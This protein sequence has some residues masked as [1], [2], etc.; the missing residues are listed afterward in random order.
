MPLSPAWC[1]LFMYLPRRLVFLILI[2]FAAPILGQDN[3]KINLKNADIREFTTQVSAITGKSFIIDPRIKGNVTVISSTA[4]D[5]DAIYELFLSVLRVHGYA[6]VPAGRV[7]KIVQQT[8]AKQS[9]NPLDAANNIDSEE[10]ITKVIP[11]RNTP[12]AELVKI[13]RPMIP[14]YGHLAGLTEP[15]ALIISD[16][17]S[18]IA[19]LME[20]VKDIDVADT[21][22]TRIIQLKEAWVE[23]M[24]ALL[25]KLAPEQIGKGA[26][27]PNLVT[28]VASER[29]N[30]LVLKGEAATLKKIEEL[31]Q[32]LDVPANRA[33]TIQVVR[34]AHSDAEQL[35][36]ILKNL[37][38]DENEDNKG[39]QNVKTSI[40]AD[41]SL[42]A[43]VI[44]ANPTTMNELKDII[45]SLDVRRLQV[46]IEA[47]IMEVSTNFTRELGTELAI[48][49]QGSSNLPIAITQ[50]SGVLA[51]ILQSIATN[52]PSSANL[53]TRPLLGGGNL[54][55]SG[56]SFA[57]IIQAVSENSDVNLLS[58]PSIT[59]MDNEEAKI[60]VGQNVPFRTG[61]T[62]TGSGGTVNPFTTIQR[63]DVGLTLKVIPHVHD[64]NSIRLEIEQEVSE[65]DQTGTIDI[66]NDGSADL[67]TNI[68]TIETTVLSENGEVVIL[69][70][71]TR[72]KKSESERGV[73][74]LK[75]IP[76]I[77]YL[78]KAESVRTEKQNLLVFIR[79]TVIASSSDME[80]QTTRKY[81]NVWEV[82][83]EGT[84]PLDKLTDHFNGKR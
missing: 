18:N 83:I 60:V 44:R 25:E 32:E 14:Q 2:I 8:L 61:S 9:G 20:M 30:S 46:L 29:T 79:S 27:G 43:L 64:G 68:R 33:G 19:R 13:L 50:P 15:N 7:V 22:T 49:D 17:A 47:V 36:E 21:K 10:L 40:H 51:S 63:E 73:P 12:S 39:N 4:M 66:G 28:I 80:S 81:D 71:L 84:D 57:F 76:L 1:F 69:G 37:V 24:V 23:D 77:G 56:T 34:L 35:A 42:N 48:V 11:V 70:G 55:S 6:A 45:A 41:A 53:G 62:T 78:F 31:I 54:D 3:W 59:T 5:A 74:L 52:D 75:D 16:H 65:V 67:I 26:K 72:D 38:S 58:T 82:V